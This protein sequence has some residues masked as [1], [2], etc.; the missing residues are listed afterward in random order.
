MFEAP[1]PRTLAKMLPSSSRFTVVL[2]KSKISILACRF[3]LAGSPTMRLGSEV[4][5]R[6]DIRR[7]AIQQEIRRLTCPFSYKMNVPPFG[8]QPLCGSNFSA[9]R[10]PPSAANA[11]LQTPNRQSPKDVERRSS[12]YGVMVW[13]D[14]PSA[15]TASWRGLVV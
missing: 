11:P 8:P 12:L 9:L 4:I 14:V 13:R 3:L 5:G 10:R 7:D 1:A 6:V 15:T 2:D